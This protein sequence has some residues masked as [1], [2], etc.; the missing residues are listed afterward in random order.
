M[1]PDGRFFLAVGD[2]WKGYKVFKI[3]STMERGLIWSRDGKAIFY[4]RHRVE[5]Q[6][7]GMSEQSRK[8]RIAEKK[9]E[10]EQLRGLFEQRQRQVETFQV[11]AGINGVLQETPVE[12]G[13]QIAAGHVLGR[14]AVPSHLK[15]ELRIPET[16]VKD[17]RLGLPASIDTRNGVVAGEVVRIDP[18]AREGTVLVDVTFTEPLPE[19]V[20][21]DQNRDGTIQIDRLDDCLKM[22]RP[23]FGSGKRT[24]PLGSSGW[25][26]MRKPYVYQ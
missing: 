15:A 26:R 21:P 8:A 5:Q 13:Q 1:S 17:V 10:I 24:R 16:Q 14:V 22:G 6:R 2:D 23:V 9:A 7:L 20:R 18:A 3:D 25:R 19:G 11:R 4:K 12:V